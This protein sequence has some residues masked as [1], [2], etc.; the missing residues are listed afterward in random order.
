MWH[1][2]DALIVVVA[3]ENT[4]ALAELPSDRLALLQ[5]ATKPLTDRVVKHEI[6]WVGFHYPTP[7][8]A[9]EAGMSLA[10]FADFVYGAC[11]IDWDAEGRRMR[12]VADRFDAAGEVRIVGDGTDLTLSLE[13]RFGRVD[14]GEHNMP[15]GEVFYCPVEDS[16]TGVVSFS[17]FP[18]VYAGRELTGIRFRF[19]GGRVV[20]A[21]ATSGE[22]FLHE[23]LDTDA[24]ARGLGELGIGC[25]PGITRHMKNAAFDEKI[26]G[27]VHLAVGAGFPE[28]GGTN[29]SSVHWD[30]VK[31]LR[32]GGRLYADG[33]LVQADGRWL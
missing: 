16:A 23:V 33:E 20:D 5:Q 19:A 4:P 18:S 31:D 24:G 14:S 25:N 22:D 9:Q 26:D 8:L 7:A 29:E 11:L 30:I 1:E 28:L 12:S 17:E 2:I 15:G 27:T 13:G 10:A 32:T 6:P 21:S 3:P